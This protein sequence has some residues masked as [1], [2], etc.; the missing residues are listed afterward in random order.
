MRVQEICQL[1]ER[2]LSG[3][4]FAISLRPMAALRR[5][6]ERTLGSQDLLKR[7]IPRSRMIR[8]WEASP[9]TETRTARRVLSTWKIGESSL[10][11]R[12][13]SRDWEM[14]VSRARWLSLWRLSR[15][16]QLRPAPHHSK[17]CRRGHSPFK[18]YEDH[19]G[20]KPKRW[21]CPKDQLKSLLI[22]YSQDSRPCIC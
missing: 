3:A 14:N 15:S 16:M 20:A 11:C 22:W 21:R 6:R 5:A 9:L 17:L 12:S 2:A 7:R 4:S 10:I 13:L 8:D 1:L 19:S 18:S